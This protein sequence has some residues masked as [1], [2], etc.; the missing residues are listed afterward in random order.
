MCLLL[1]YQPNGLPVYS[2]LLPPLAFAWAE[3]AEA[4]FLNGFPCN[5]SD[6]VSEE[7]SPAQQS[8][9][10]RIS[11]ARRREVLID[12]LDASPHRLPE[13]VRQNVAGI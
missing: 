12:D 2:H 13:S 1:S 5:Q 4:L 7:I 8:A 9:G 6:A 3:H 10:T 11:Q